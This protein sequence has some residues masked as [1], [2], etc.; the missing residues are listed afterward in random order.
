ML[1]QSLLIRN[2]NGLHI[3][4]AGMLVKE[5][6]DYSSEVTIEFNNRCVNAKSLIS[7]VTSGIKKGDQIKIVCSGNDEK[8]VFDKIKEI[9]SHHFGE[10]RILTK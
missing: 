2:E 4:P 7:V 10:E 1:S 8:E 5:I 3:R 6:K 9:Y